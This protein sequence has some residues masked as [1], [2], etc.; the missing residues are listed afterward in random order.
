MDHHP[1]M[2]GIYRGHHP[3]LVFDHYFVVGVQLACHLLVANSYCGQHVFIICSPTGVHQLF[4]FHLH[5]D[6]NSAVF[7]P[8]IQ[9]NGSLNQNPNSDASCLSYL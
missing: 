3:F 9:R 7:N 6:I 8:F 5:G 1:F 4:H 2:T